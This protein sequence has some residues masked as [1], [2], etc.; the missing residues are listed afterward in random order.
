V[1]QQNP[2]FRRFSTHRKPSD[3]WRRWLGASVGV[4]ALAILVYN[5][6]FVHDR[7]AWRIDALRTNIFYF[8][9][10]PD[11]VVFVPQESSFTI[12]TATAAALTPV[13]TRTPLAPTP[14]SEVTQVPLPPS[15][16]LTGFNYVDQHGGWN[17]C[18]PATL[19]MALTYWGWDGSR[20]D[21]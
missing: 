20:N 8:L 7:L 1:S 11:D 3:R 4:L 13:P 10:P 17:L 16:T 12:G 15:V 19:A 21:V 5:I 9:N 2:F 18:G 14:T 6:P